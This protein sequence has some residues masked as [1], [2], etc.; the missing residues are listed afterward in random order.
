MNSSKNGSE[1]FSP[2]ENSY[3]LKTKEAYE[4]VSIIIKK[5]NQT[6]IP[7]PRPYIDIFSFE[8]FE[9]IYSNSEFRIP[10]EIEHIGDFIDFLTLCLSI[11]P[12]SRITADVALNH[13]F[14]QLASQCENAEII[15]PKIPQIWKEKEERISQMEEEKLNSH[16]NQILNSKEKMKLKLQSKKV[17][18]FIPKTIHEE[19]KHEPFQKF[20][21]TGE[22]KKKSPTLSPKK[23]SNVN[24]CLN[25]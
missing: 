23:G 18:D 5:E 1:Y 25:K 7:D 20:I 4:Q 13:P 3:Q 12:E 2:Y 10:E 11:E 14:L 17:Q 22:D 15:Q 19:S 16:N 8:F 9:E 6:I 24:S 21:C